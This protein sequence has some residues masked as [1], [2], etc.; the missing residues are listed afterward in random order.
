[1]IR[2]EIFSSL[3]FFMALQAYCFVTV[4][5]MKTYLDE[6]SSTWDTVIEDLLNECTLWVE[7]YCGGRRFFQSG[8]DVTEYYDGTDKNKIFL[9]SWPII[10]ITSVSYA[11]GDFDNPTWTAFVAASEY[12][13]DDRKGV[14]HFIALPQGIQNIKVVYKGG[15]SSAA[16]VPDDLH[17]AVKKMVAKEFGRRKSQGV[18]GESLGGGSISWNE[19]VDPSLLEILDQYRIFL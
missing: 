1:M 17:L 2:L 19:S 4:A 7:K 13:R 15:Y 10:S 11:T 14:L 3:I 6:T 12:K 8:T 5:Q 18:T 9:R 16:N